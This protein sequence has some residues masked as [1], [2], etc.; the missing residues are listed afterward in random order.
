[1]NASAIT[2]LEQMASLSGDMVRCAEANDWDQLAGL[3][4]QL[5]GLRSTLERLE[6][7]GRQSVALNEP[8]A[9][10]KA[11]LAQDVLDNQARVREHVDPWMESTRKLIA[12][13]VQDRRVRTAYGANSG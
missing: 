4:K 11:Q 3:G 8:E 7:L 5:E 1:M 13:G 9:L 12:D 6:P 10:R 2:L